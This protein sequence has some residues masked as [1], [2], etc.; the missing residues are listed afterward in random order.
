MPSRD[1]RSKWLHRGTVILVP[2]SLSMRLLI[3]FDPRD[4]QVASDFKTG[5]TSKELSSLLLS[6]KSIR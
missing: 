6:L 3:L 1:I 5:L 2:S 4:L